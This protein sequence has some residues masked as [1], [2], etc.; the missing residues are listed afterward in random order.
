MTNEVYAN[1]REVACKAAKGTS[2]SAFPDVCYTPPQ[3][4]A[5]PPGIPVPYP[6][7]SRAKDT[8]QGSKTVKISG[9]EVMLRNHSCFKKSTG[10]EAGRAPLKGGDDPGQ[11][12][13]GSLSILVHERQVR[14]QKRGSPSGHDLS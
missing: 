10:D 13:Q 9:K 4:P 14:R 1:G 5:A 12:R 7:N 6:N 2:P 8:H 3:T 11:S